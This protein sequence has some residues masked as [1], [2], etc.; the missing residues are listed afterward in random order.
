M[1]REVTDMPKC[2]NCGILIPCSERIFEHHGRRL[3]ACSARCERIYAEYK[4]PRY[5]EEIRALE[6]EGREEIRIGYVPDTV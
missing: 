3:Y 1:Y 5:Q 2:V 6:S 4:Y